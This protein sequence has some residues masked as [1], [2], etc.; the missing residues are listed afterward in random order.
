MLFIVY[1]IDK[2]LSVYRLLR[3]WLREIV[4]KLLQY[5]KEILIFNPKE[6]S[7][8]LARYLILTYLNN[9]LLLINLT[10][11]PFFFLLEF[12]SFSCHMLFKVDDIR[13]KFGFLLLQSFQ[14]RSYFY[15]VF[16]HEWHY[17]DERTR[18]RMIVQDDGQME[19]AF[20]QILVFEGYALEDI[21]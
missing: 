3:I 16:I 7:Q 8:F 12:C 6:F 1:N 14:F 2:K 5:P 15:L 20:F 19:N 18:F 17:L 13:L 21:V 9:R 10:L 4:I 11:Q